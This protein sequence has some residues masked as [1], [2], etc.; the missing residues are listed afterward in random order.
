LKGE[1]MKITWKEMDQTNQSLMDNFNDHPYRE[2]ENTPEWG[3]L[4]DGISELVANGDLIRHAPNPYVIG[5]LCKRLA[6]LQ[7]TTK[8]SNRKLQ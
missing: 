7:S 1:K 3:V 8:T 2:Y 6:D 4:R 5:Y